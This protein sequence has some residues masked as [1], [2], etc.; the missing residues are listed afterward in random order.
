MRALRL[1]RSILLNR[2]GGVP[3][4]S[5]CTYLTTYRCN[6][7]CR[8]CDS[9]R[10]PKGAE[11]DVGEAERVFARLGPLD[12]VRL[13]GGEPFL[14]RD[15]PDLAATILRRSRPL[16]LHVTT[17][18]SL[19]DEAVSFAERFP[20]PRR[21][22]F[23]VSLDGLEETHDANRG[24]Q[25]SFAR[26]FE[27]LTRLAALRAQRGFRLSV[28]HTV[29]SEASMADA[30]AL[31]ARCAAL[32]ID[33]QTVVA[34]RSSAIYGMQ[35]E[36]GPAHD[37][38]LGNAYPLAFGLPRQRTLEFVRGEI[39]RCRDLR[40]PWLRVGKRFYLEGLSERLRHCAQDRGPRCV[41][42]RSHV[43]LLPDGRVPVCQFNT[44]IVGSLREQELAEVWGDGPA[45]RWR[46]WVDACPGCWAECE[47]IPNA[48]YSGAF[49]RLVRNGA[50]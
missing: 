9:W 35:E 24:R 18:G 28:N 40:D 15:L 11:M 1:V 21:L 32:G 33:V 25:A 14:R 6:A 23:M 22:A 3:K 47:V 17:N 5:W 50:K 13:T 12:V 8:M 2:M 26:A 41:A 20:S 10:I 45:S 46:R 31:R 27:T 37:L 42:L 38:I 30:P 7:R 49:L 29:V 19:T 4:P 39:R 34:Y 48:L 36:N 16:S 44:Q 43:R